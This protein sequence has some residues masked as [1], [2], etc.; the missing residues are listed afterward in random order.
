ML[1]CIC[2]CHMFIKVRTY[3]LTYL[4][5][6]QPVYHV[7]ESTKIVFGRVPASVPAVGVYNHPSESQIICRLGMGYYRPKPYP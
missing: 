3:L 5:E 4:L 7:F 2:V 1:C 6:R